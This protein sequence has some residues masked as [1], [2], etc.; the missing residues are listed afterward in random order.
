M[1]IDY[2]HKYKK[3]KNIARRCKENYIK[4]KIY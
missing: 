3:E 1:Y 2:I 4:D